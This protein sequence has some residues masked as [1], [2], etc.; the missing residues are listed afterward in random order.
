MSG[1]SV[2]AAATVA[3]AV[4]IALAPPAE[5]PVAADP[6]YTNAQYERGLT[7]WINVAR[8]RHGKPK[9]YV[10]GCVDSYAETWV[11]KLVSTGTFTH[12]NLGPVIDGCN[13]TAA[14]EILASGPWTPRR[15]VNKWLGSPA[16]RRILLSPDYAF[17]GVAA[18]SD[19]GTWYGVVDFG[20]H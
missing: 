18:D 8:T 14:A 7:Y 3:L 9:L 15:M 6:A 2:A 16:H 13:L 19:G 10:N 20:H 11:R 5:E 1:R 17:T 4:A 12:Q